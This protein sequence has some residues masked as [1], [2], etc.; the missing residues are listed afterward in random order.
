MKSIPSTNPEAGDPTVKPSPDPELL[1]ILCCPES[2]QALAFAEPPLIQSLNQQINSGKVKNRA[3]Q[4]V[5]EKLDSG[6]V[7]AD[8]LILYPIRGNLPVLL[9]DEAIPL[10]GVFP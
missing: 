1:K 4:P 9:I 3:G 10:S 8:K 5:L 7:R 6:L 2:H